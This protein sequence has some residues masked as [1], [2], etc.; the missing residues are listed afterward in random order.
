MKQL[1]LP[2]IFGFIRQLL[3][4]DKLRSKSL[5]N[6]IILYLTINEKELGHMNF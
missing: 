6:E 4:R 2:H 1:G 3:L 5:Y